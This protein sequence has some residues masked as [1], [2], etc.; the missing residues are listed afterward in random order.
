MAHIKITTTKK[1]NLALQGGGA[2]GAYTWGVLDALLEDGRL[3]FEAVTA[4]SAGSM[5]AAI[6]THGLQK[7]GNDGARALLEKFWRRV[8]EIGA[9]MNPMH[10]SMPVSMSSHNFAFNWFDQ[11]SR[12]F[13]PYQLNPLNFNPL[14]NIL[15]EMIDFNELQSNKDIKLFIC[16][17][18]VRSGESKIFENHELSS[19]VLCASA[20]LPNLFQAVEVN[21]EQYWDGG[22]MGNPSLWPLFYQAT[23]PDILIVHVNPIY[24]P[25]IPKDAQAIENRVNEITFNSS[26]MKELRSIA[27]VQKL[28][29]DD[30]LKPAYKKDYRDM[31][32]H[33]IRSEEVMRDLNISSKFD[34]SWNFLV[35][36]RDMGRRSA[37]EW[38]K[39]NYDKI[40]NEATI[41]IQKDYLSP[42]SH[43]KGG[44]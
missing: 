9:F 10:Q 28:V 34:T 31:L 38:I 16:A 26:L 23:T 5:N 39:H 35:K 37:H 3:D 7:N 14:K 42:Q 44:R 21:G 24:R 27:F 6:L 22:Y 40:G 20:A 2:H 8:S 29:R 11:L 36:L 15:N 4:T 32:L 25:E 41:D 33:A 30:M 18:N 19:D 12:T 1:I 13:S 43:K 17:T